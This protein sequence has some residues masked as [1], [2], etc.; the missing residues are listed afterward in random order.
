[1]MF[2]IYMKSSGCAEIFPWIKRR[3]MKV[4]VNLM[5]SL[6]PR[7]TYYHISKNMDIVFLPTELEEIFPIEFIKLSS[8]NRL[9]GK[10]IF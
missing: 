10:Q 3:N 1:M 2:F 5:K 9:C 4:F 7:G 6:E 8:L